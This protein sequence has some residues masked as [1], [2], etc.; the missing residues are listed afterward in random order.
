MALCKLY[1]SKIFPELLKILCLLGWQLQG[2]SGSWGSH[3]AHRHQGEVGLPIRLPGRSA[4]LPDNNSSSDFWKDTRNSHSPNVLHIPPA[5]YLNVKHQTTQRGS[6]NH[7]LP[8]VK[9]AITTAPLKKGA[10]I[11]GITFPQKEKRKHKES[12]ILVFC[13]MLSKYLDVSGKIYRSKSSSDSFCSNAYCLPRV[14][15]GGENQKV[16]P[17]PG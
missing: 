14:D 11:K 9:S 13:M 4:C 5:T 16:V 8:I 6:I 2:C 3:P 7:L 15:V 17:G 12:S 10:S 1:A